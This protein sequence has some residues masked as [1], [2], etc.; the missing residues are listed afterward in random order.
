VFT[1]IT[2]I[3]GRCHCAIDVA[4]SG[5]V[6]S[7]SIVLM[8]STNM[9]SLRDFWLC[10][11]ILPTFHPCGIGA[12]CRRFDVE[13]QCIASVQETIWNSNQI[14]F[15]PDSTP[16]ELLENV[17]I[18][19]E[20]RFACKGLFKFNADGVPVRRLFA[21]DVFAANIRKF[22]RNDMPVANNRKQSENS[23]RNDML[24]TVEPTRHNQTLFSHRHTSLKEGEIETVNH[25][26]QGKTCEAVRA[27]RK[28]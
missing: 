3:T 20:L 13:T 25:F 24:I 26:K 8:P 7:T 23:V 27:G 22:R 5:L 6:E 2:R 4:L 10:D 18:D 15:S 9:S 28:R 1:G 14:L 16:T 17:V 12:D 21:D 11:M 19:P